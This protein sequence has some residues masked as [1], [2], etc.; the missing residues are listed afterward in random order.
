MVWPITGLK[1]EVQEA[2]ESTNRKDFEQRP[3]GQLLKNRD[4]ASYDTLA[5]RWEKAEGPTKKSSTMLHYR[6]A[7]RMYVKST[8]GARQISTITREDIQVFLADQAKKYSRSALRSMR[9]VMSM[10]LGWAA[11][12][13]WISFNP[14]VKLKLPREAGGKRTVRTVLTASQVASLAARLDEPYSTLVLLLAATGL[15]IGEAIGVQWQDIDEN[16]VLS[17]SRRVYVGDVDTVK[18]LSSIRRLPLDATLVQRIR[19][20][21]KKFPRGEWVFQS[22]RGT[23]INPGN[24]MK[25]YIRPAA[26]AERI[27][28]GGYH[29]F[30]HTLSTRLRRN[31]THPKVVSD[32]L[33]HKK[34][35]LAM[36]VYDRTDVSD[37][38]GPLTDVASELVSNGINSGSAA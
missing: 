9:T 31:G 4:Y 5:D 3:T 33:G 32:I 8:F 13:S 2:P 16:N 38:V 19:A 11:A 36:D 25:R 24:A 6:N 34:V 28:M 17:V 35:N 30:R 18:A 12:N 29:D 1:S 22:E 26:K 7:I 14:C 10:T 23:T 21:R 27:E 37:L 20:L 15:R